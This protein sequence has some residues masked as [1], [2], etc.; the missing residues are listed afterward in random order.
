MGST[1][2]NCSGH[3]PNSM[4]EEQKKPFH[5]WKEKY[6]VNNSLFYR[7]KIL[8]I[9]LTIQSSYKNYLQNIRA[10]SITQTH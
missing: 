5:L 8:H 2:D 7:K 9:I 6:G 1:S 4:L 3:V 10:A